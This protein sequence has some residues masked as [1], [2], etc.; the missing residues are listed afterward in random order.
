MSEKL[1]EALLKQISLFNDFKKNSKYLTYFS[2]TANGLKML[3]TNGVD[4][5]SHLI[6]EEKFLTD[7]NQREHVNLKLDDLFATIHLALRDSKLEVNVVI[8][9]DDNELVEFKVNNVEHN[10]KKW[11]FKFTLE[12]AKSNANELKALLFLMH[13]KWTKSEEELTRRTGKASSSAANNDHDGSAGV[14]TGSAHDGLR[15]FSM[16]TGATSRKAGMSIINPNSK[17]RIMP[18]GVKFDDDD[19]DE[20]GGDGNVTDEN[21]SSS[22][23]SPRKL[24][25]NHSSQS[26]D[27]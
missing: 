26:S 12:P 23:Q 2:A 27:N 14:K 13:D 1:K 8:A 15:K 5:W 3:I 24:A 16:Q 4:V 22:L 11:S 18:K 20:D 7:L 21:S 10:G 25:R 9:A 17:R 6:S 19:E